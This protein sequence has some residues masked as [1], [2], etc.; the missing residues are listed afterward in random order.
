MRSARSR[1][2]L[3]RD[4]VVIPADGADVWLF[5]YGTLR[6]R[7]VQLAIFGRELDGQPDV[8]PG[9]AVSTLRITDPG[10]IAISGSTSHTMARAT[11]NPLDELPGTVFRITAAEL[12]AADAYEVADVKRATVRLRSG[13]D[14]FI[15]IDAQSS[16]SGSGAS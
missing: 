6:Q 3:T 16:F 2:P 1:E 9:Y 7:E 13:I 5:S 10:V 14:A 8:L 12:T 4:G 15:Y 11:G